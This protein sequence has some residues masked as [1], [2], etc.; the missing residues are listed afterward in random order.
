M[1]ESKFECSTEVLS[2]EMWESFEKL[3][4][5]ESMERKPG[6]PRIQQKRKIL[7]GILY[8]ARTGC[9]WKFLPRYYGPK[10]TVFD[11]FQRWTEEGLFFLWWQQWLSRYDDIFGLHMKWQSMDTS[12][13]KAPLGG[14][15]VGPN[16]TDRGKG[17]CK[18]S[19]LTDGEG[20]PLA[21]VVT[22]ANQHDTQMALETTAIAYIPEEP[23]PEEHLCLD[24]GYISK[25]LQEQLEAR[26]FLVHCP[27]RGETA[28]PRES[29]KKPRR[30]V[31]ERTF[32]WMNRFRRVLIRWEKL[33]LHYISF[34]HC[35]LVHSLSS[36]MQRY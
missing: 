1:P 35:M 25:T 5:T 32:S 22:A 26:G 23:V 27:K 19:I 13:V 14:E 3:L 10:S 36:K 6:R 30:W 9:H 28:K 31:V 12:M 15:D 7:E 34:I 4:K 29:G 16:P 2:D 20:I 8:I 18:R 33:S 24:K 17:G 11:Y 21:L